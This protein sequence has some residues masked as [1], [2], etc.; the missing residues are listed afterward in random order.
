M[1]LHV[2]DANERNR[3]AHAIALAYENPTR[4]DPPG[5]DLSGRD[6]VEVVGMQTCLTES[7]MCEGSN[8]STWARAA[9]SG[10]T[11]PNRAWMST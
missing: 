9:T 6:A 2:V 10:T 5:R 4:S 1:A 11:P 8:R 3:L 7:P